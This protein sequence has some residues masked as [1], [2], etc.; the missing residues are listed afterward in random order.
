MGF[1]HGGTA[2]KRNEIMSLRR[3][4]QVR[5]V[6]PI[7]KHSDRKD[8]LISVLHL[9][10]NI[11]SPFNPRRSLLSTSTL[12]MFVVRSDLVWG[13]KVSQSENYMKL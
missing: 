1:Q 3:T 5:Y 11:G 10:L 7:W 13:W 2:L 9:V 8:P 6:D 12:F 4:I